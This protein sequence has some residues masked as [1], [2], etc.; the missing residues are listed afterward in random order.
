MKNGH[1]FVERDSLHLPFLA[2]RDGA[3]IL[4]W[5]SSASPRIPLPQDDRM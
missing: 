1:P 5:E 3:E 2:G 4:R